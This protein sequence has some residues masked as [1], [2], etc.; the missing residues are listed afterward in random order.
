MSFDVYKTVIRGEIPSLQGFNKT[1]AYNYFKK[2]LGEANDIDEYDNEIDYF[3][4]QG[5]FIPV[6][7]YN[8]KKWGVD[9][10]LSHKTSS[11]TYIKSQY[12]K[13]INIKEFNELTEKLISKFPEIDKTKVKYINYTWYNSTEEPI[14]F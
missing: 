2:I 10:V 6:Y 9:L 3:E 7:D 14:Y 12:D 5:E 4:Y 13:G 8:N 1:N 11:K